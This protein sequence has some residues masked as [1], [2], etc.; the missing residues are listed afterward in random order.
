MELNEPKNKDVVKMLD[1]LTA[2]E[3]LRGETDEEDFDE[4]MMDYELE[5][6]WADDYVEPFDRY[7]DLQTKDKEKP[8]LDEIID[9]SDSN[10]DYDLEYEK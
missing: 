7:D 8:P 5:T 2:E 10:W 4:E 3:Q 1:T 6:F 9:E